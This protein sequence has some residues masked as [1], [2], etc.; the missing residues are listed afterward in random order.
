MIGAKLLCKKSRIINYRNLTTGVPTGR[1]DH[2][3]T[4]GLWYEFKSYLDKSSC[5][6]SANDGCQ[7]VE[8]WF[9]L[10][11]ND[12]DIYGGS[13]YLYDYFYTIEE[14]RDM[15]INEIVK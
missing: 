15:I 13:M 6:M 2:Y 3:N 1:T 7:N 5:F 10:T 9:S 8:S 12:L 4:V 11:E 14:S